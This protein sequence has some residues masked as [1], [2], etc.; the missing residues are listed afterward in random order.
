M[1][2]KTRGKL[3]ARE[4]KAQQAP[5]P[6]KAALPIKMT[7]VLKSKT[8]TGKLVQAQKSQPIYGPTIPKGFVPKYNTATPIKG[9]TLQKKA[10]PI[11][12]FG[13]KR[14]LD[15]KPASISKIQRPTTKDI[16][17][18]LYEETFRSKDV[19][20]KYEQKDVDNS[21]KPF[22][23][24]DVNASGKVVQKPQQ[25]ETVSYAERLKDKLVG[26]ARGATKFGV[27][28]ARL[29]GDVAKT[30]VGKGAV[31]TF[32]KPGIKELADGVVSSSLGKNVA[33]KTEDFYKNPANVRQAG[34]AQVAVGALNVGLPAARGGT[35]SRK[36]GSLVNDAIKAGAKSKE[37]NDIIRT[38]RE[39]NPFRANK[40]NAASLS[41]DTRE[42]SSLNRTS[43]ETRNIAPDD[44]NVSKPE[45]EARPKTRAEIPK[46]DVGREDEIF[47]ELDE[48]SGK[49]KVYAN[50]R[51]GD[52][53]IKKVEIGEFD[54]AGD[55]NEHLAEDGRPITEVL[56]EGTRN[57]RAGRKGDTR[58]AAPG[59]SRTNLRRFAE[60]RK[61]EGLIT[62]ARKRK[63]NSKKDKELTRSDKGKVN[64]QIAAH[65]VGAGA[66][67]EEEDGKI[68]YNPEKGLL[69]LTGGAAVVAGAK[70]GLLI[71]AREQR[72]AKETLQEFNPK[73]Y[74]QE[75]TRKQELARNECSY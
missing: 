22:F 16:A 17:K 14:L 18:S 61:K 1:A 33:K 71:K 11:L 3:S 59:E 53:S 15:K 48:I 37:I 50:I 72:I 27:E 13:S 2:S 30:T 4:F 23:D 60:S 70:K 41:E 45:L 47:E 32:V 24:F 52:G 68:R 39:L 58:L 56:D 7:P 25:K 34:S 28:G 65:G 6:F 75:M 69:G 9:L 55:F 67:F 49:Q 66:G 73:T 29:I 10:N 21:R 63:I 54:E 31:K 36:T 26:A 44:I 74:A 42:L 19:L 35:L 40:A 38:G 64:T 51:E 62:K 12:D 20:G 46:R 5:K 57:L 43:T 8:P